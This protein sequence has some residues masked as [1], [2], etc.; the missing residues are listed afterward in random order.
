MT[1]DK[2]EKFLRLEEVANRLDTSTSTV[3]RLCERGKLPA[4]NIGTGK[5]RVWRVRPT[6][7]ERFAPIEPDVLVRRNDLPPDVMQIG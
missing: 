2:G 1:G 3:R 7:L 6:D 4:V 5:Q